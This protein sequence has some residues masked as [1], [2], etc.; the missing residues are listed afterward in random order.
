MSH[1]ARG[2]KGKLYSE[3]GADLWAFAH[4]HDVCAVAMQDHGM[5]TND[6]RSI[7]NSI[8]YAIPELYGNVKI[9]VGE[10]MPG[11]KKANVGGTAMLCGGLL[12]R[13]ATAEVCDSRGWGRYSGR[14]ITGKTKFEPP[15]V[16]SAPGKL[17]IISFYGPVRS[18]GGGSM[19][20]RQEK[21]ILESGMGSSPIELALA[22]LAESIRG[23]QASGCEVVVL[24]DFN[25]NLN[26]R[27]SASTKLTDWG[28]DLG[29]KNP[30]LEHVKQSCRVRVISRL[31]IS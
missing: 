5:S 12:A 17:A 11:L 25:I 22:D 10:G 7:K 2:L 13:H 9:S 3:H 1:N 16:A 6:G 28:Q 20:K 27:Q 8:K 29:L 19:W 14:V 24:G 15:R 31:C 26:K 18:T 23:L 4:L 30:V 21:K